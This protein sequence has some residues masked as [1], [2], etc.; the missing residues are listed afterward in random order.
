PFLFFHENEKNFRPNQSL[1]LTNTAPSSTLLS[2]CVHTESGSEEKIPGERNQ[3]L[4]FFFFSYRSY[5]SG[6]EDRN[7]PGK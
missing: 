5:D 4:S 6:E 1:R 7:H 2:N 3:L